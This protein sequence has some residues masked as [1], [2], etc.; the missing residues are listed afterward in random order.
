MQKRS[1]CLVKVTACYVVFANVRGPSPGECNCLIFL[2]RRFHRPIYVQFELTANSD[3]HRNLSDW[4]QTRTQ[5]LSDVIILPEDWKEK[6]PLFSR[7]ALSYFAK[8]K[9]KTRP[10]CKNAVAWE[11]HAPNNEFPLMCSCFVYR[12]DFCYDSSKIQ[13][14]NLKSLISLLLLYFQWLMIQLQVIISKTVF[15]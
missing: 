3:L 9:P 4:S 2:S 6:Q 13:F 8:K 15:K 1:R 14:M 11:L 7:P 5:F 10:L 12:I